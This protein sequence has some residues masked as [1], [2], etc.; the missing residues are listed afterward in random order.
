MKRP[1]LASMLL[2]STNP[3]RL[4]SWYVTALEPDAVEEM[5]TY[6]VLQFGRFSLVIDTRDDIGGHNP[7]PGRVILNFDVDDARA[8]V[9]RVNGL[10]ST[11]LAD[12]E[13]RGGSLF[14]TAVDPD[15]NYVQII[16]LS[17][18]HRA[19]MDRGAASA[20]ERAGVLGSRRP[21]SGFAVQDVEAARRFYGDTL[22][23][24][25]TEE[26]G[27]L[28]ISLGAGVEVL[29]YPKPDH[30]PASYTIL[31]FPVDDIEKAVDLL[32]ERGVRCQRYDQFETDERGIFRGGGPLIAWFTDPSG[33]ILSVLQT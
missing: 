3:D 1:T 4:R 32:V 15:G 20:S 5:D 22:G 11:W 10:G 19:A 31:N 9:E 6:R 8:V 18:E 30:R 7:E 28:R 24:D 2:A 29:V 17:D 14:A 12:L 21:F 23:L 27:L 33:N 25:V 26:N 16:Q 13:D